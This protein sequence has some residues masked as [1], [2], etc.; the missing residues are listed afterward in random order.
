MNKKQF[1]TTSNINGEKK[2]CHIQIWDSN[3]ISVIHNSCHHFFIQKNKNNVCKYN[4]ES[5]I[6]C[7]DMETNFRSL[8]YNF[9]KKFSLPII[10]NLNHLKIYKIYK[11]SFIGVTIFRNKYGLNQYEFLINSETLISNNIGFKTITSEI[12]NIFIIED[13]IIV[14]DISGNIII[15]QNENENFI[16]DNK[17]INSDIK[18]LNEEKRKNKILNVNDIK[19][20]WNK[21]LEKREKKNE[22]KD[23]TEIKQEYI[24]IETEKNGNCLFNSFAKNEKISTA[25]MR[26]K[27]M[28][29]LRYNK[30][31]RIRRKFN[32]RKLQYRIIRKCNK[33]MNMGHILKFV[34]IVFYFKNKL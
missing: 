2:C 23:L 33:I 25:E 17:E 29:Y 28:E 20:T 6:F 5:V 10:V 4:K 27:I 24:I 14:L 16:K 32:I 30:T 13:K 31:R 21:L 22:C 1:L 19:N 7:L 12:N 15:C 9:K 3:K 26:S 18:K 11:N 34:H 8:Y